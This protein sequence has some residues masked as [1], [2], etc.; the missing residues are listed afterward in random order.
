MVKNKLTDKE[1]KD[2]M[3][4]GD[5]PITHNLDMIIEILENT[6]GAIIKTVN[7]NANEN[8]LKNKFGIYIKFKMGE[9]HDSYVSKMDIR[10]AMKT[11]NVKCHGYN[12]NSRYAISERFLHSL[13]EEREGLKYEK[14]NN[15]LY[16]NEMK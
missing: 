1:L 12:D 5:H 15:V 2:L 16:K 7:N 6:P 4:K 11:L 3:Q 8:A 9:K 10:V 13:E 14:F